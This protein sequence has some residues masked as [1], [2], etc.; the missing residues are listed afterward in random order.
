MSRLAKL[1]SWTL[2]VSFLGS[3]PLGTLNVSITNLSLYKGSA[4]AFAFGSAAILVELTLVR[5]ALEGFE[6]LERMSRY[7]GFFRWLALLVLL[8]VAVLSVIAAL[9]MKKFGGSVSIVNANPFVS[10]LVLSALNPLH[11]PFW[12]SWTAAFKTKGLLY[13]S[14]FEH[15]VYVLAIGLGTAVAFVVYGWVGRGLIILLDDKQFLLNWAVGIT[16]FATAFIQAKKIFA[17]SVKTSPVK[18]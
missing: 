1:F 13:S 7:A 10:G 3:L 8:L 12:L 4:A 6:R 9:Q 15:N 16:L 14:R 18:A 2:L 11:L 17:L 5:L